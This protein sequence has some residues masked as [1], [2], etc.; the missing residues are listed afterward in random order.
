[1]TRR[2]PK[3]RPQTD[4]QFWYLR[5]LIIK[6]PTRYLSCSLF[7]AIVSSVCS[8]LY[9]IQLSA[10]PVCIG[11]AMALHAATLY[12]VY[13]SPCCSLYALVIRVFVRKWIRGDFFLFLTRI[14]CGAGD[15]TWTHTPF[16]NRFWVCLVCHSDTPACWQ[17]YGTYRA[18]LPLVFSFIFISHKYFIKTKLRF[19]QQPPTVRLLTCSFSSV[20]RFFLS[21]KEINARKGESSWNFYV[22]LFWLNGAP[23]RTWTCTPFWHENLNLTRMPISP[24]THFN[25]VFLILS[26]RAL[27]IQEFDHSWSVSLYQW[28]F[29]VIPKNSEDLYYM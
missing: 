19:E 28:A 3:C 2:P 21:Q 11:H 26:K 27:D 6:S 17:A 15:G 16:G 12:V 7:R 5:S 13:S 29:T 23:D 8:V 14:T 4:K 24:Q 25:Y 20:N 9:L 1:M 10:V 22:L 18:I